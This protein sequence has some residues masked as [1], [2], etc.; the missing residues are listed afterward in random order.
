MR[1]VTICI[2]LSIA[3]IKTKAQQ[4]NTLFLMH[5]L[6]QSNIVNPSIPIK[7]KLH[8]AMPFLGSTHINT[9]STGFSFSDVVETYNG[10]SL[11]FN[12]DKAIH[13][14]NNIEV[15]ATEA[16]ISILSIGIMHKQ[17]YFTFSINEKV[18][19][20]HSLSKNAL[21][22]ANEGNSQFV[23]K[24][25]SMDGT[26]INAI[27]YRE[28]AL[29]WARKINDYLNIGIRAK[30][31]FGKGNIYTKPILAR[32]NTDPYTYN[33]NLEGVG[34]LYSSFPIDII[35]NSEGDIE[36]VDMQDNINWTKYAL[37]TQN[38]GVGLDLGMTYQ[39]DEKTTFSASLLDIGFIKWNSN[40]NHFHSGGRLDVSADT[41]NEG[42]DD[43]EEMADTLS[44]IFNPVIN[45]EAYSTPLVPALYTGISRDLN[46]RTNIGA[47]FHT[48]MYQNRWHPSLT[49]SS[50]STFGNILAISAS[51]TIQN[52][53]LNNIGMGLG[54]KLGFIYLHAISDNVPAF[55]DLGKARNINLRFGISYLFKCNEKSTERGALPC[56]GE[57]YRA[58]KTNTR[59]PYKKK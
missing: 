39:I 46:S 14:F 3:L 53:Q 36:E 44:A 26:R 59:K 5:D 30:L 7:C 13:K 43:S 11:R 58:V 8:I 12:P 25:S 49:F 4:N 16:H 32:L 27:H 56:F 45:Q 1:I 9:Y 42:L 55:F 51:Y 31:L 24:Y 15:V 34:D 47:V 29:G 19:T 20:Y 33:L 28:Y 54:A 38:K 17:N 37:N 18:N 10:D 40:T 35:T 22:F 6:P 23:G 48:E 52:K 21:I 41:F 57:P 50:N 2:I